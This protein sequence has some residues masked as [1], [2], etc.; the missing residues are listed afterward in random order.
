ML[1]Q[2]RHASLVPQELCLLQRW[3]A[4]RRTV[5]SPVFSASWFGATSRPCEG[6]FRPSATYVAH[7]DPLL[8]RYSSVAPMSVAESY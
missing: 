8:F 4:E 6:P 2:H 7:T 3:A 5:A 1:P